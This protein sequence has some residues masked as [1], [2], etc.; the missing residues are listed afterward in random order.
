MRYPPLPTSAVPVA[1]LATI[2]VIMWIGW[3][4]LRNPAAFW[5]PGDLS[6]YHVDVGGCLGCHEPFRGPSPARCVACHSERE[7]ERSPAQFTM[8]WHRDI[9]QRQTACTACH[10]EHRGAGA[11]LTDRNKVDPHS[12]FVFRATGLKSC[13]ACHAFGTRVV[14]K[15][16]LLD[17]PVVTELLARGGGAHVPGRMADCA[18]CHVLAK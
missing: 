7:P 2:L 1:A 11:E 3:G 5:A 6:R 16:T 15:P 14:D 17:V 10:A 13:H 9:I 18:R 12:E 8:A 4:S